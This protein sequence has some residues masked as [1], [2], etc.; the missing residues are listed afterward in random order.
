[1]TLIVEAS[2]AAKWLFDEA[3]SEQ[4]Q[5]IAYNC[6]HIVLAQRESAPLITADDRQ[7]V[8]GRKVGI[9]MQMLA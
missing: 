4:A 5:Q 7:F 9:E 6:L 2:I 1:M 8:I 3:G